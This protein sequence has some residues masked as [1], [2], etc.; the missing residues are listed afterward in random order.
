MELV[1]IKTSINGLNTA[2]ARSSRTLP[3]TISI[4]NPTSFILSLRSN[5]YLNF[6]PSEFLLLLSAFMITV[7]TDPVVTDHIRYRMIIKP[8]YRCDHPFCFHFDSAT[9]PTRKS[10][11]SQ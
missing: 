4:A 8:F 3:I 7:Y 6:L 11:C 10:C 1:C 2:T 5:T 9:L